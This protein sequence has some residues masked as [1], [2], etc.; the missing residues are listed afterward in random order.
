VAIPGVGDTLAGYTVERLLGRGGMGAV[1]LATHQRLRRAAALKVLVPELAEDEAFRERFIRESELAASLEHPNV[2]PI[3]DADEWEG[4]L[5]IAMKYV[6]GSDL[7]QVLR[8]Q[9]QLSLERMQEIV[10][11]VGSAL[12]AAHAA[13]L[14][15]R[16]VKPAN[17]LIEEPGGR[18][19]L[20]DFGVAKRT[21]SAG[22][23]KTGSFLGSVDYCPPEQIHGRPLDGRA[24]VYSLGAVAF[25]CLAG[26]P[27]F[28]RETD[29][30]VIQAHLTEPVPALS[31]V[32]PGLPLALDGVIATAMAKY[33]EVRYSTAGELVTALRAAADSRAPAAPT[34]PTVPERPTVPTAAA[35]APPPRR[36][37]RTS[38]VVAGAAL[39][40]LA[41]A[42]IAVLGVTLSGGGGSANAP[43]LTVP[44]RFVPRTVLTQVRER[45]VTRVMPLQRSV[46][47][48]VAQARRTAAS[49][50]GIE[51]SALAL[52]QEALKSQGW[53]TTL[54]PATSPDRATARAL[55]QAL[56]AQATYARRLAELPP[57]PGALT[58]QQVL[59]VL[60]AAGAA[61]SAYLRLSG[62][63]PSLP[64]M[65]LHRADARRLLALVP[66]PAPAPQATATTTVTTPAVTP[67]P[68]QSPLE[69]DVPAIE[70]TITGHWA[71]ID[72]GDYPLAFSYFSPSLQSSSGRANWLNDKYADRPQSSS[73]RFE[74]VVASGS[75]ATAYVSFTTRGN[76]TGP[77]NTG[78]NAW[79]GSYSMAK[80]SGRWYI[81]HSNLRRTGQS[82]Y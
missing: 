28:P 52:E 15:H 48:R 21:S 16:D 6:E 80:I 70:D 20:S 42:A 49:L 1:Y 82:C 36:R 12:G 35:E 43:T 51:R 25:H 13:G 22:L 32:R 63:S 14:V 60:A 81:D 73:I 66:K 79:S 53:L 78:C 26:Q 30:A 54:R 2:V 69:P 65:P 62:A 45:L 59:G 39:A 76:E 18:V 75:T 38:W 19:Y 24:D 11:Q 27:P 3:Y 8:A 34:Q 17:V 77:G 4:V 58:K 23:T 7:R 29:V 9:G 46:T 5:F 44:V 72:A 56:G 47:V 67:E 64:A 33:P 10:G 40:L 50:A 41:A 37:N 55:D 68:Q 74:R 61:E 57:A 31:T 71:A